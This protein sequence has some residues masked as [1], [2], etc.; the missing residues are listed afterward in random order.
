MQA[1]RAARADAAGGKPRRRCRP[2]V[3]PPGAHCLHFPGGGGARPR[4]LGSTNS[5]ERRA[6]DPQGSGDGTLAILN[7]SPS[8]ALWTDRKWA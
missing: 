1:E 5:R 2:E 4:E 8:K 3:A 7:P 6:K